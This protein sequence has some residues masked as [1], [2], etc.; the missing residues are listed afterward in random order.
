MELDLKREA[1]A[2]CDLRVFVITALSL[3]VWKLNGNEKEDQQKA[4]SLLLLQLSMNED[5]RC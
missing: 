1:R 2:G 5:G 3:V 4:N